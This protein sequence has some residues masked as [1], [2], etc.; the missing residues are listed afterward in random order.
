M[1]T[2]MKNRLK[3][4]LEEKNITQSELARRSGLHQATI[5]KYVNNKIEMSLINAYIIARCLG[6]DTIELIVIERSEVK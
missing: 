6:V 2:K 4:I 3:E 1:K 5:S